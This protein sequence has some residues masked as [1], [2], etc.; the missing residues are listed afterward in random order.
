MATIPTESDV[1][2]WLDHQALEAG[3]GMNIDLE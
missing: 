2:S 3:H 1:A